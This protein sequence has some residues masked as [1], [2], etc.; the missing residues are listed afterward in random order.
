MGFYADDAMER[1]FYR[2]MDD[3][4]GCC[5]VDDFE[6]SVIRVRRSEGGLPYKDF[7]EGTSVLVRQFKND[8]TNLRF[9]QVCSI[10]RRTEKAVLFK[11]DRE[12]ATDLDGDFMFWIPKSVIYMK[13]GEK[14]VCYIKHWG[15]IKNIISEKSK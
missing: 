11:V 7:P 5:D 12:Y 9:E 4:F 6:P 10:E 1:D 3:M 8:L 2:H 15:T 14:S 13:E